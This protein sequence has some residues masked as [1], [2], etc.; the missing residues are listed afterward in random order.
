MHVYVYFH[1][2]MNE[3]MCLYSVYILCLYVYT[4]QYICVYIQL[5]EDMSFRLFSD[6]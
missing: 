5:L 2:Y 4:L 3:C 1:V 6:L